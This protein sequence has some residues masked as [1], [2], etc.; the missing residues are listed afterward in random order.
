[1]PAEGCVSVSERK[2]IGFAIGS[3]D[4]PVGIGISV[5]GSVSI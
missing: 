4:I 5:S 2:S 3:P 1:M